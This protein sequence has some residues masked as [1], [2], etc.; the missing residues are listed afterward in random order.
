VRT[1]VGLYCRTARTVRSC[2][3]VWVFACLGEMAG[4]GQTS[5]TLGGNRAITVTPPPAVQTGRSGPAQELTTA[6]MVSYGNYRVFGAAPQANVY[7][8]G[9]EYDR[10]TWGYHVK[11]QIDYVVEF[12][13]VAILSQPRV[14]NFWGGAESPDNVLVPGFGFTPFGFRFLWRRGCRVQPYMMG[15][16][17]GIFFAQPA[18]SPASS[19]LNFNFQGEF[20]V[21]VP[22]S[23]HLQL[24]L[25]PME[26][27]HVSNGYLM[28]SNPGMD[29]LAGKFGLSYRFGG[30][31]VK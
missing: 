21:E 14:E 3:I 23:E 8:Q 15:K 6:T 31:R 24:R 10:N 11:A 30:T 12:L 26:Y 28:P 16:A 19:R 9:I 1:I 18:L 4:S 27:F 29:Q 17:G 22:V 25:V 13:P 2:A 5:M 7:A 20:G